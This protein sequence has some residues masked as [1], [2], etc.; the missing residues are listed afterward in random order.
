MKL[1]CTESDIDICNDIISKLSAQGIDAELRQHAPSLFDDA[2]AERN[3]ELHEVW[4]LN[5]EDSDSANAILYPEPD[6]QS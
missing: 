3:D 2:N 4:I 5:A 1:L 6:P